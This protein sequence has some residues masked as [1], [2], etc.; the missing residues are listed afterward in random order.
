MRAIVLALCAAAASPVAAQTVYPSSVSVPANLLR[1]S[2]VFDTPQAPDLPPARLT[3]SDG[4]EIEGAFYPQRLWSPD[5][6][7]LTLYLDPGRV[8]TGLELRETRGS[9]LRT[10]IEVGLRLGSKVLKRWQVGPTWERPIEP[11]LGRIVPPSAG[12]RG[13]V[14]LEFAA[15]IDWQGRSLI[16]IAG[17]DGNRVPGVASLVDGERRW[18]FVPSTPWRSGNYVL[19]L[20]PDLEDSAGNRLSGSFESSGRKRASA[21]VG[22]SRRFSVR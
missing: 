9:I 3:A 2:I 22:R 8:K 14:G 20:H 11:R 12:T 19:R 6:R 16:A 13:A 17:P 21:S 4:R 10:G 5:G 1:V 18:S 15:P 7:T